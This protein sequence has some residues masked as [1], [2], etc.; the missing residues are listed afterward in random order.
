MFHSVFYST[1]SF[2]MLGCNIVHFEWGRCKVVFPFYLCDSLRNVFLK[3]V[4]SMVFL[5]LY[6]CFGHAAL[7]TFSVRDSQLPEVWG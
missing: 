4:F 6:Y 5:I 2:E 7:M 3:S 1:S